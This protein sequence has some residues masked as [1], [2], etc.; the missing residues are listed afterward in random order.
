MSASDRAQLIRLFFEDRAAAHNILFRHRHHNATPGFH[1][2]IIAD[3]ASDTPK[4][5]TMTFRGG[6]KSTLAEEA[7]VLGACLREY[8]NCVILGETYHRAVERLTAIKQELEH[9]EYLREVFGDMV[10]PTWTESKIVLS[11]GVVIQSFGRGQSLRGS[12]H[13]DRRPD[14][15]FA[16]DVEDDDSCIDEVAIAK[17]MRWL[18]SVVSPALEPAARI[19]IA[20]TPLHPKSVVMQLAADQDW[21]T[22]IIPI[23]SISAD[24]ERVA[25]WPDRFPLS[26]IDREKARFLRVGMG[27]EYAQEFMCQA[28][29]MTQKP[30]S[31][32]NI[33]VVPR[34]RTWEAAYAFFD[35]AR[36]I[37]PK[38]STTGWAVW[39]W[40]GNRLIVWDAGAGLWKPDR[41]IA[42]VF[43]IDELYN[44]VEIGIEKT[45]LVDFI[46]QPLRQE[47]LK[48]GYAV[49]I[50]D[51]QAPR[52]KLDF[53]RSLQPFFKAR[54]VELAKDLP[55]LVS[56]LLSFPAGKIDAPNALAYALA[57]RPGA[58]VFP[59]FGLA[60]IAPE[61][62]PAPRSPLYLIV[63][64]DRRYTAAIL[65]QVLNGGLHVLWDSVAEGDP[66]QALAGLVADAG[67]RGGRALAAV[68]PEVHFADHDTIGL[69]AA[70][71]RIPLEPR[72]G[73]PGA[74]GREKMRALMQHTVRGVAALR[75]DQAATWTLRALAGG[76]C[77]DY[78]RH[79]Q[80][81]DYIKPGP[82]QVLMDGLESFAALFQ[83]GAMEED[84][85]LNY[86]YDARGRRYLSA[87]VQ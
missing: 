75:I 43:R 78:N 15:A 79:G 74:A 60:H 11:N 55:E 10:G 2:Q 52:G 19:R 13:L 82:Y 58:P 87:L 49:P 62:P 16:D 39:S 47:M 30:F 37:G 42:E 77:L 34:I 29:D 50:R 1:Y 81:N 70:A 85:E 28:E 35:P 61:I 17:T 8:R 20:G 9:N 40:V 41:I 67:L 80:L 68:C 56:Q 26:W 63:N 33:R 51:M 48:R 22:R 59:D 84:E 44:P 5:L 7:I 18:M 23:E 71:K 36:S 45:G 31:T 14:L 12:K 86:S 21:T 69:R 6:A 83:T 25:A 32:E 72:A 65:A 24:G 4:V 46:L 64:A 54:E 57:M 27:T 66:G 53:I 73:G 76:Y 38:S 3:W